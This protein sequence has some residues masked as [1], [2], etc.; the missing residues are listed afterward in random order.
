MDSV[1]N[2]TADLSSIIEE[3]KAEEIVIDEKELE[4][5]RKQEAQRIALLHG[6]FTDLIDFEKALLNGGAD[7]HGSHGYGGG[8]GGI[9]EHLKKQS[10]AGTPAATTITTTTATNDA[11]TATA[12][13][14]TSTKTKGQT[15]TPQK[16]DGAAP[17][18]ITTSEP[19]KVVEDKKEE[20][21]IEEQVILGVND[22]EASPVSCQGKSDAQSELGQDGGQPT[23]HP[24]DEL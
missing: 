23:T 6:G 13:S 15:A 14:I 18:P 8:M 7:Y 19:I 12:A 3:T 22:A 5:E 2:G 11:I 24:K 1:L 21:E 4:I 20:E 16:E 17:K 10:K 9:P